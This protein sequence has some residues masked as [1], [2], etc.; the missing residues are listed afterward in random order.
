MMTTTTTIAAAEAA[1]TS[2]LYKYRDRREQ[3]NKGR[4]APSCILWGRGPLAKGKRPS[5]PGAMGSWSQ[6]TGQ[7]LGQRLAELG[8]GFHVTLPT[9]LECESPSLIE[10]GTRMAASSGLGWG[11][12]AQRTLPPLRESEWVRRLLAGNERDEGCNAVSLWDGVGWSD[13]QR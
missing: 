8:L 4:E 12:R 13:V 9:S 3:R 11:A 2:T 5:P 1:L 6:S 7:R 10:G